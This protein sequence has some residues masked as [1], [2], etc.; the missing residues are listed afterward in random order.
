MRHESVPSSASPC[1]WQGGETWVRCCGGTRASISAPV[2][3]G[4]KVMLTLNR[5]WNE[6]AVPPPSGSFVVPKVWSW[7]SCTRQARQ[8]QALPA[9]PC[10]DRT[11]GHRRCLSSI[12]PSRL[13][14][15]P[16]THTHTP[17]PQPAPRRRRHGKVGWQPRRHQRHSPRC[18][19]CCCQRHSRHRQPVLLGA[20]GARRVDHNSC[21]R[22]SAAPHALG[23]NVS[24]Q[25]VGP[26]ISGPAT[27]RR[28]PVRGGP[29]S[30]AAA[31]SR[32]PRS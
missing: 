3:K 25:Q 17:Q 27:R 22:G 7:L 4:A 19:P 31:P 28:L 12:S 20:L 32:S 10:G 13:T 24:A 23:P 30:P 5:I 16:S 1:P 21:E 2:C 26:S 11:C 18:L 15:A 29:S 14:A 6:P 9:R 8:R